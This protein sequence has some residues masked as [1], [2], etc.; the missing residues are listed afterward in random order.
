MIECGMSGKKDKRTSTCA[1]VIARG[2]NVGK[3]C[4]DVNTYCKN[5]RHRL[6]IDRSNLDLEKTPRM[7]M[8]D[9]VKQMN[10]FSEHTVTKP[11][12][13]PIKTLSTT[14]PTTRTGAAVSAVPVVGTA[15][16]T[17]PG[18]PGRHVLMLKTKKHRGK[19]DDH[20]ITSNVC[21][22]C[23]KTF[24]KKSNVK[25]HVKQNRCPMYTLVGN[26]G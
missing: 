6:V 22:Y 16:T 10:Y 23:A 11:S 5:K 20:A 24:S 7:T 17:K 8:N 2:R 9:L 25:T 21:P 3:R 13:I 1:F 26:V 18:K 19:Y 12:V 15:S 4:C 14:Q